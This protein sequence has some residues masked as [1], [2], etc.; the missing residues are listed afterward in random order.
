MILGFTEM[1]RQARELDVSHRKQHERPSRVMAVFQEA[2][3]AFNLPR[4]TTLGELAEE[5][6]ALGKIY[7]G[8]PLYVDVRLPG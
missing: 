2:A 8:L 6:G 3:L 7:G 5:L 4:E 1:A